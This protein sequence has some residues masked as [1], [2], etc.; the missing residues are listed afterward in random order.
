MVLGLGWGALGALFPVLSGKIKS[1][2]ATAAHMCCHQIYTGVIVCHPVNISFD[3]G[4]ERESSSLPPGYAEL[5]GMEKSKQIRGKEPAVAKE[6]LAS[7]GS[8]VPCKGGF[9]QAAGAQG[10]QLSSLNAH[11]LMNKYCACRLERQFF[12]GNAPFPKDR[13]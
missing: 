5:T 11:F 6:R 1:L 8:R 3:D 9:P 10:S 2:L 13:H 12:R 4:P 7:P